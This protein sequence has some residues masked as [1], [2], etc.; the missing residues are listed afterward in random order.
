MP[1]HAPKVISNAVPQGSRPVLPG[2]QAINREHKQHYVE[3]ATIAGKSGIVTASPAIAAH[4][5]P[6]E[7]PGAGWLVGGE[8]S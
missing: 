1:P 8:L 4:I 7:R 5:D 2:N 6:L 3:V